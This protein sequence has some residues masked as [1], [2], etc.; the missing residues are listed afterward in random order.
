MLF[1]AAFAD[2][3]FKI[4]GVSIDTSSA[5]I[6]VNTIGTY[7]A[8]ITNG[9][10]LI[11]LPNEHK[12]YFDI[13]SAVLISKKQDLFFSSG[14]IQEI[15]ISQFTTNP[16]VVRIVINFDEKFNLDNLKI[17]NIN[18]HL[19][20]M[21]QELK[22]SY[23]QFY[24]NTYRDKEKTAEDY[25]NSMVIQT[26]SSNPKPAVLNSNMKHSSKELAQIQQAFGESTAENYKELVT[27]SLNN[28]IT[29][30]VI[31]NYF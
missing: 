3:T 24:Q 31:R 17:G 26:Q 29:L 18:N 12:I 27:S 1:Q 14:N 10:K 19:V 4:K 25:Y 9:I 28:K 2:E 15:K 5:A 13:N 6:F 8:S 30:I 7:Q 22:N 16:N 23:A 20:I 11:K 21:T